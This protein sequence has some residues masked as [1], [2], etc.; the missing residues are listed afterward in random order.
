MV[1][2]LSSTGQAVAAE[3]ATSFVRR[4]GGALAVVIDGSLLSEGSRVETIL[5]SLTPD[6]ATPAQIHA[7]QAFLGLH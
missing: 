3:Q 1:E 6:A 7:L 2:Q 5:D 4:N